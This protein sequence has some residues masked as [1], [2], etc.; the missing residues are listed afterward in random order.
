M[1]QP[2]LYLL[3]GLVLLLRTAP[4]SAEVVRFH[5]VPVAPGQQTLL[6]PAWD[7]SLGERQ[8]WRGAPPRG[9]YP[10]FLRPTHLVTVVHPYTGNTLQVPLA[11]PEDTPRIEHVRNRLVF[12]Y[13]SYTVEL[14]FFPD[15]SLDVLY[16]A[17]PGRR[18]FPTPR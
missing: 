11:L 17:G 3:L 2:R 9:A 16:N 7:G 1:R 5:Y 15:G 4:S 13:G 10:F 18:A 6:K 8:P 12:N 14:Q